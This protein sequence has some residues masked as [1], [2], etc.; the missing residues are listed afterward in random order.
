[1]SVSSINCC[2]RQTEHLNHES[3]RQI[4]IPHP[5][6]PQQPSP[7]SHMENSS[8]KNLEIY[9][10][11]WCDTIIEAEENHQ[12]QLALRD[13]ITFL[14]IFKTSDSCKEYIGRRRTEEEE[15][16]ITL[17]VSGGVGRELVPQIHDCSYLKVIYVYCKN[18]ERHEEWCNLYKKVI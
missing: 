9:S 2:N 3:I 8:E 14:R 15:E 18:K 10:L 12:V 1:L 5:E 6:E 16:E 13:S 4:N 17:V 11:V 7:Q